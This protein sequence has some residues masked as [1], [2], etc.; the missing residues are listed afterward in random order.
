M[1]EEIKKKIVRWLYMPVVLRLEKA[2]AVKLW[3]DGVKQ[4]DDIQKQIGRPR[5]YLF[6]NR[7]SGN[8]MPLCYER[9]KNALSISQM[10]SMGKMHLTRSRKPSV[11]EIKHECFYYTHSA[12]GAPGCKDQPGMMLKKQSEWIAYYLTYVSTPMRKI[13]VYLEK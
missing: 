12:W 13:T 1:N 11:P 10:I 2:K 7:R 4:C 6:Y 9:R 3:H 5:F 8:W